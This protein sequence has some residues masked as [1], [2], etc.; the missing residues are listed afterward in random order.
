VRASAECADVKIIVGGYP[1]NIAPGLWRQ[2]G[3]DA[4]GRDALDSVAVAARL[5]GAA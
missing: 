2:I 5:V 1:F 4:Y 3:A